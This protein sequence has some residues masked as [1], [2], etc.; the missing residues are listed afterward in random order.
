MQYDTNVSEGL[1]AS[2]FAV[3]QPRRLQHELSSVV[4]VINQKETMQ[5]R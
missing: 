4:N 1:A 3:S 2:I 5:E